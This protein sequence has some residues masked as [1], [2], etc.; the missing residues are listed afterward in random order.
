[1]LDAGW[2]QAALTLMRAFAALYRLHHHIRGQGLIPA[3]GLAAL[4]DD[5]AFALTVAKPGT[6]KAF[7][8]MCALVPALPACPSTP[9]LM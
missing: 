3:V 2:A 6:S 1:M 9:P 8:L 4:L 5:G 7:A